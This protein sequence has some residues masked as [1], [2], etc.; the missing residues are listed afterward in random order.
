METLGA[1]TDVLLV[2]PAQRQSCTVCAVS[3]S[4]CVCVVL[5][6]DGGCQVVMGIYEILKLTKMDSIKKK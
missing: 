1:R 6:V 4:A 5:K 3:V 2:F